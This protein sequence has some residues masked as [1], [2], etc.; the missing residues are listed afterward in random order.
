[1]F[2][3]EE[4]KKNNVK[5]Q[6]SFPDHIGNIMNN[7]LSANKCNEFLGFPAIRACKKTT[8]RSGY[9]LT[10]S[11]QNNQRFFLG[12]A[13]VLAVF[14][15][16]P[17]FS[18]A[19]IPAVLGP[20]QA[21][22]ALLP[23]IIALLAAT[24]LALLKPRTYKL[25]L[26]YLW[27]HKR[28]VF[29]MILLF[30]AGRWCI[31]AMQFHDIK[32]AEPGRDWMMY[33]G[34]ISRTG[35]VGSSTGPLTEPFLKWNYQNYPDDLVDSTPCVV[36]NRAYFGTAIL[37]G[38][39]RCY[40]TISC[41]DTNTGNLVWCFEGKE[42]PRGPLNPLFSSPAA[43][44]VYKKLDDGKI[45]PRFLVSGEGFHLDLGRIVC[46]DL[47]P[48]YD[49]K[50]AGMPRVH[51]VKQANSHVESSPCV[52]NDKVYIGTGDDGMWCIELE[53]GNVLW[54]LE[55]AP[56]YI[57]L[58]GPKAEELRKLAGKTVQATG[59][60]AIVGQTNTETGSITIDITD[61]KESALPPTAPLNIGNG[62]VRTVF[63]KV[64]IENIE[65][66]QAT[67]TTKEATD[68][69]VKRAGI[70]IDIAEPFFDVE[71]SPVGKFVQI[72][73]ND[74]K[75][76]LRPCVVVGC[77]VGGNKIVCIDGDTGNLIWQTPVS[78]P[79][80]GSPTMA[81]DKVIMGIGNG[82]MLKSDPKPFGMVICLSIYDGKELWHLQLS[83]SIMGSVPIKDGLAY[84]CSRDGNL[85]VIDIKDGRLLRKFFTGAPM[86]CSPAITDD[87]VYMNTCQGKVISID[88]H[89]NRFKW[90]HNL[91]PGTMIISSP[92]VS[93]EKLLVGT[94]Q[95]GFCCLT[96]DPHGK[97]EKNECHFWSGTGGN[98]ARN[99]S[100]CEKGLPEINDGQAKILWS[101][102][103]KNQLA[104]IGPMALGKDCL[105]VVAKNEKADPHQN[106]ILAK[107]G[108]AS[109]DVE[110]Q[111]PLKGDSVSVA[112]D[113]EKVFYLTTGEAVKNEV[114]CLSADLGKKSWSLP[115][116]FPR[117]DFLVL[118]KSGRLI[119]G[120]N[121]DTLVGLRSSNGDSEWQLKFDH[122]LFGIPAIS[123]NL[124]MVVCGGK[125]PMMTCL[126]DSTGIRLWTVPL[127]A[128]PLTYPAFSYNQVFLGL[129]EANPA[130]GTLSNKL[131][132]FRTVNGTTSWDMVVSG[133]PILYPVVS[134]SIVTVPTL[135]GDLYAYWRY[136]GE[137]LRDK[138]AAI[139]KSMQ[140]PAIA[141]GVA[142]F[143]AENRIGAW[144]IEVGTYTWSLDQQDSIGKVMTQPLPAE[145]KIFILTEKKGLIAV[146]APE[147]REA[148]RH[149]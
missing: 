112:A 75:K 131:R 100:V 130:S 107:V 24:V 44:G 59:I 42:L 110:W 57:V 115:F 95:K 15:S 49:E 17:Q 14:L 4:N 99:A 61:V 66:Q 109:G 93:G 36:G 67:Q 85:Y 104:F 123:N 7:A 1:M 5:N 35:C 137:A 34:G 20:A 39:G 81:D 62:F 98:G 120:A 8:R 83:D 53:S 128:A 12:S 108:L 121:G 58:D 22:L 132:C 142:L 80:F 38:I 76:G 77:G 122:P 68:T 55:G 135:E 71:S 145:K 91:T 10:G 40:G 3:R 118:S 74:P 114:G 73:P 79:A 126:D 25:V 33:A 26:V 19:V 13:I 92:V 144:N 141:E 147:A 102:L 2:S 103:E 148:E 47:A 18:F 45:L 86:T 27:V 119:I 134:D 116:A 138:P 32:K 133:T 70:R 48:T 11:K 43:G 113:Q 23:Q 56:S 65:P 82:D 89:T 94:E 21:L 60:I 50:K 63:G 54:H 117:A 87:S 88:R 127:N 30:I 90:S 124:I 37:R 101:T 51:W 140:A 64:A 31:N 84:A 146:G 125:D 105:F 52:F 6:R 136:S 28:L 149:D 106:L 29:T 78:Y 16:V 129:C 9:F 41:V 46:L 139:G 111:H 72:D 97:I 96:A 143:G 69:K